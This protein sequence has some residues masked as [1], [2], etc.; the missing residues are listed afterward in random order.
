[1]L[2][3]LLYL[4]F[5][6]FDKQRKYSKYISIFILLLIFEFVLV[7]LDPYV[8]KISGDVPLYNFL[9]NILVAI[10]IIPVHQVGDKLFNKVVLDI[11]FRTVE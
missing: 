5:S 9:I 2:V 10:L 4:A 7:W 8:T 11:K 6:R 3:S 1:M